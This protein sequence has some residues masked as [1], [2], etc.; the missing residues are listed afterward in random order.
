MFAVIALHLAVTAV[1]TDIF[2]E[3]YMT[4]VIPLAAAVLAGAVSSLP[5]RPAV[6]ATAAL[7]VVLGVAIVAVRV[8]REYEPDSPGAVAIADAHGYRTIL[9][10]SA[11][12]A[13]Y[14]R[15]LHTALDRPFGI[16]AG[17]ERLCAPTCAV[18]DNTRFGGVRPGP[19]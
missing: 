14:G 19:G 3:R 4:T 17:A 6:P 16:G 13:F 10:N 7:L 8:G 1:D 11:V 18:I 9:T 12:V 5:W 15:H 2:Q